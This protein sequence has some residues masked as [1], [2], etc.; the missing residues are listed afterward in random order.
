MQSENQITYERVS[1][2]AIT[3]LF[4]LLTTLFYRCRDVANEHYS[5]NSD[6]C[7]FRGPIFKPTQNRIDWNCGNTARK[8]N[9]WK[10]IIFQRCLRLISNSVKLSARMRMKGIWQTLGTWQLYHRSLVSIVF[11]CFSQNTR[12][13]VQTEKR[14][15]EAHK[16]GLWTL[17]VIEV[18]PTE[19]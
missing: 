5:K 16:S 7:S 13:L 1:M 6:I 8:R 2:Q 10:W 9:H 18:R 14:V 19:K 3:K 12:R 17:I 15:N 4:S 11:S